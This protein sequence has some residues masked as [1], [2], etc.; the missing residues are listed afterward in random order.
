MSETAHRKIEAE[1]EVPP[2]N[3]GASEPQAASKRSWWNA[4]YWLVLSALLTAT[5]TLLAWFPLLSPNE[6]SVARYLLASARSEV[7]L[8]GA[9]TSADGRLG[10]AVGFGGTILRTENGGA[11]WTAQ[12]S[13]SSNP[14]WSVS[15]GADGRLGWAVGVRGTILRTENGGA[16]WTAQTSGTSN[17]LY[18]VSMGAD[19]RLG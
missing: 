16:S 10:W 18:S 8:Y 7:W 11:S 19:G 14:L 5:G 15:M 2:S 13:G 6:P 17:D 12:T 4:W 9:A 3:R 1:A